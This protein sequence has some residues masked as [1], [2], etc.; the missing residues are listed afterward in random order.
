MDACNGMIRLAA[1]IE[2]FAR[3]QAGFLSSEDFD[4]ISYVFM[5]FELLGLLGLLGLLEGVFGF[6][7]WRIDFHGLAQI[8]L[9][10]LL[11]GVFGSLA[12]L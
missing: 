8:C 5:G 11:E 6:L 3:F 4:R 12:L 1:P 9:L 2:T 7:A 10:G